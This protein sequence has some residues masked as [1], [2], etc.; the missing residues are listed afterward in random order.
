MLHRPSHIDTAVDL[1]CLL[2]EVLE[3]VRQEPRRVDFSLNARGG[4]RPAGV[5]TSV[6]RRT[7]GGNGA[8]AEDRTPSAVE[9][10]VAALRTYRKAKG[11]KFIKSALLKLSCCFI[12]LLTFFST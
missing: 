6:P 10:R 7:G 4:Q 1:A 12:F 2:E 9:D 8:R 3:T 11:Y 5:N